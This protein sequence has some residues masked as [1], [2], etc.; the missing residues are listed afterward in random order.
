MNRPAVTV[1]MPACNAGKFI[2]DSIR[3]ALAQDWENFELLVIDDGSTDDT[4]SVV[5]GFRDKRIR[6]VRHEQ[7]R[8]LVETLNEGLR[9]AR[10]PLVAR[11][12]ADDLSRRDRLARQVEYFAKSPGDVAVAS[13][14]RLIDGRGRT[15][16]ALRLPRTRHQL[17]WDL[18]FRNPI[19]HSSVM[20]RREA[21]LSEFGGYPVST[22]SEDYLL[23]SDIAAHDRFGLIPRRLVSYR[24][25]SLSAMMSAASMAAAYRIEQ[26][27]AE[28]TM[29]LAAEGVAR[30]RRRNM[31]RTLAECT[32]GPQR[33]VLLAAW[34]APQR[35]DWKRYTEVFEAAARAYECRNGSLG[36]VPGIEYQTLLSRG[37]PSPFELLG[38]LRSVAPYR[39][40]GLPWHRILA[41]KLLA[42]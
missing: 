27:S 28:T 22:S 39:I 12:D 3:S 42:R 25:H 2:G 31:E 8:G 1:L 5:A 13:E 34:A 16:G 30:V 6:L 23:W 7:N 10:A 32:D 36:K 21:V 9:G 40:P 24:V 35:L 26:A 41:T 38:A 33:D 17:L 11:Q 18:C 15:R 20:M 19:P 4:A 14:A 29:A 37:A